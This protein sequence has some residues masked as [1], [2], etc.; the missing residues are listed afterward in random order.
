MTLHCSSRPPFVPLLAIVMLAGCAAPRFD[1][2][3]KV[4]TD[5]YA[6][7]NW[8]IAAAEQAEAQFAN[9]PRRLAALNSL[10][11]DT[12]HPDALRIYAI[13]QLIA[14]DE[15]DLRQ[16]LD[17]RI[18][19]IPYGPPLEHLFKLAK[20]RQWSGLTPML[21]KRWAVPIFATPD[22]DRRERKWIEELNPGRDVNDIVFEVFTSPADAITA[23]QRVGAWALLNRLTTKEKLIEALAKAPAETALVADLKAAAADLH[24]LPRH[25]EGI[26]HLYYLRDPSRKAAWEQARANVAKLSPT[27]R[28]GLELRHLPVIAQLDPAT[29]A[30]ERDALLKEL[31]SLLSSEEHHA[32]AQD[33]GADEGDPHRLNDVRDK[34]TWADLA[35]MKLLLRL[36]RDPAVK[37]SLFAQADVDVKDEGA[38]HGG[39]IDIAGGKPVAKDHVPILGASH[40]RQYAPREEM[41]VH[42]YTGLAHYHFHAQEFRNRSFAAPGRGDLETAERLDFNFL[43]FTFI[44]RDRLN[45]DY[46]QHGGVV[47]DMGT[48]RR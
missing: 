44:D 1:D 26:K 15:N 43:V 8:R 20:D 37:A 41:I 48:L 12:G 45:V 24:T 38:E 3:I 16:K 19:L 4:M 23:E 21:V 9:D 42:C 33:G 11:W 10:L 5:K 34:V 29:L 22:H 18:V 32:A 2:P 6:A 30:A 17:R 7:I 31:S 36:L 40:N 46:Y 47:V 14:I 25:R 35:T 27:Q 28:V 13:D 39:V